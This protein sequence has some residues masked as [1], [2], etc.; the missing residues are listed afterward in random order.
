MRSENYEIHE[1][2]I[3]ILEYGFHFGTRLKTGSGC[4]K[5]SSS[6]SKTAQT[7][8]A[9]PASKQKNTTRSTRQSQAFPLVLSPAAESNGIL[10]D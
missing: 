8:P 9:A 5:E 3:N 10:M 7:P 6:E 2:Q 4:G 1:S